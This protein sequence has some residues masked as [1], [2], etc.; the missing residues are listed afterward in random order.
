MARPLAAP[1]DVYEVGTELITPA[2][3][4]SGSHLGDRRG[5]FA[6]HLHAEITGTGKQ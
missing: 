5:M 4:R 1:L 3:P 2:S 6:E